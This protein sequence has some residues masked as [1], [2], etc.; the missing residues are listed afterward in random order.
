MRRSSWRGRR[1]GG[2]LGRSFGNLGLLVFL[3]RLHAL[4]GA[5]ARSRCLHSYPKPE[6]HFIHKQPQFG[7]RRDLESSKSFQEH[8]SNP[9]CR[10]IQRPP[11][12]RELIGSVRAVQRECGHTTTYCPRPKL[13]RSDPCRGY[14]VG[15][16]DCRLVPAA[17]IAIDAVTG[18]PAM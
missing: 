12:G 11:P 6:S 10:T 3:S 9:N 4:S 7:L 18:R 14:D 17:R 13:P 1:S 2:G 15:N 5:R 16:E 8:R